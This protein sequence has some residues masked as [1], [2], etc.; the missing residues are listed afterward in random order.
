MRR[1]QFSFAPVSEEAAALSKRA[2]LM[3]EG[4]AYGR[5]HLPRPLGQGW[6]KADRTG[7]PAGNGGKV[8][9]LCRQFWGGKTGRTGRAD[10]RRGEIHRRFPAPNLARR[11]QSGPLHR[12]GIRVHET[13]TTLRRF[14]R[15][16]A[17]RRA[18]R[19]R[20]PGRRA[21]CRHLFRA[22]KAR[23]RGRIGKLRRLAGGVDAARYGRA[24]G[25]RD[26]G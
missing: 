2:R 26:K 18:A 12:R 5:T 25:L 16:G 17:S 22:H 11:P 20:R 14:R 13:G 9:G 6:P 1:R 19:R 10:P 4:K 21:G 23:R 3:G 24:A 8:L 7:T 15:G